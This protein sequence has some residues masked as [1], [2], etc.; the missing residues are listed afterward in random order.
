[1]ST[2]APRRSASPSEFLNPEVVADRIWKDID[3]LSIPRTQPER[4]K[5]APLIG[6]AIRMLMGQVFF[7]LLQ[8][9]H[10]KL[11][12]AVPLSRSPT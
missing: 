1:M 9:Q 6:D 5:T 4:A 10:P 12:A 11:L 8:P 3:A 7:S 2:D